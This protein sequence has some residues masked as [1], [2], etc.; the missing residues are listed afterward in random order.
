MGPTR[1]IASG[2]GLSRHGPRSSRAR[3]RPRHPVF[4]GERQGDGSCRSRA[5]RAR[6][7]GPYRPFPRGGDRDLLRT[8]RPDQLCRPATQRCGSLLERPVR[9]VRADGGGGRRSALG[10]RRPSRITRSC[11]RRTRPSNREC[12]PHCR[13]RTGPIV[14]RC[15]T[16]DTIRRARRAPASNTVRC[17][18]AHRRPADAA[19]PSAGT[20]EVLGLSARRRRRG[21]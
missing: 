20:R 14:A 12:C 10:S 8:A 9:Q 3:D 1:R 13:C 21:S 5:V 7:A 2:C 4:V 16:V 19:R 6:E 17:H 11:R 15:K 18:R